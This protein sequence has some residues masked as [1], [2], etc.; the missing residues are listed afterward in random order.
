MSF[1]EWVEATALADWVRVSLNGYPMMITLHSIGLAIMVGISVALS[2]RM[3][4]LFGMLPIDSLQGF[5]RWAWTGFIVNT[6]SGGALWT[7]QAASY[8]Q[9]VQ[10]LIKIVFVFIGAALVA[11]LQRQMAGAGATW[12]EAVP[13]RIKLL[14][15]VTILVW[16]IAMVTGRLIAYL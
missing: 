15:V 12:G 3:L 7:T 4:G 13:P 6:I 14:A 10:F 2:L 9:N 1:L 11:V 16:T 8:M 5:F